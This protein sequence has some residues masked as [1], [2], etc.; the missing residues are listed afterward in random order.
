MPRHWH[1]EAVLHMVSYLKLRHNTRLVLDPS[2]PIIDHSNF[3]KCD[4]TDF[5]EGAVEAVPPNALP[6]RVKEVDL[7]MFVI[8]NHVGNKQTRRSKPGS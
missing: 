3:R 4:L 2:Y 8:S 6:L 1:L 5:Y 7:C